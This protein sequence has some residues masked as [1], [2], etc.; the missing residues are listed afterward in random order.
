MS[1]VSARSKIDEKKKT[2]KELDEKILKVKE[3]D[4]QRKVLANN[5]KGFGLQE[6][7]SKSGYMELQAAKTRPSIES[8]K[9]ADQP[10]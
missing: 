7:G 4:E 9:A 10:S 3:K 8:R 2:K 6:I 5:G 1:E